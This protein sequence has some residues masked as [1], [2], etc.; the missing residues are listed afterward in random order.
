MTTIKFAI[1]TLITA[2]LLAAPFA[3]EAKKYRSSRH[4]STRVLAPTYGGAGSPA[5]QPRASYGSSGQ[6]VG[7]VTAPSIGSYN[8]PSV[9]VTNAV[10][11]WSNTTR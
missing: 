1:A 9:G 7:T 4:Y 3:A 2:G 6:T 8:W 10:P 11:T 5:P